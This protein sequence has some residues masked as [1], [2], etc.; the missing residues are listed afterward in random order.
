MFS[1]VDISS[2]TR[3]FAFN[4]SDPWYF[5][6]KVYFG[7]T[8]KSR[9]LLSTIPIDLHFLRQFR[10]VILSKYILPEKKYK[11]I[12]IVE[13]NNWDFIVLTKYILTEKYQGSRL[14]KAKIRI[15]EAIT[16]VEFYANNNLYFLIFLHNTNNS[17]SIKKSFFVMDS[18]FL[19]I[20]VTVFRDI[21][22][23]IE[24]LNVTYCPKCSK[25]DFFLN[26][27]L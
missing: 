12:G 3:I 14:M 1:T 10:F 8:I 27:F 25:T 6:V 24:I 2:I 9:L 5:S 13:N 21:F 17:K 11:S 7:N 4:N 20:F 23:N 15:V 22:R 18:P 16:T 19:L 26:F